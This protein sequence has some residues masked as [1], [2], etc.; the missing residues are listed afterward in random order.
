MPQVRPPANSQVLREQARVVHGAK[1]RER[2]ARKRRSYDA[3]V[4]AR[5]MINDLPTTCGG[6]EVCR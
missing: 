6:V 3:K 2:E 1:V 5:P 4:H